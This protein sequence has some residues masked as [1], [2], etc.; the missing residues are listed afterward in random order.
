MGLF[1]RISDIVSANLNDLTEHYENPEKLLKQAI[2]EMEH[3]IADATQHTAR[4]MA[5]EKSLDREL[6]RNRQQAAQWHDRAQKAVNAGDDALACRALFRRREH[7]KLVAALQDQSNAARD[8]SRSL[9][10]Q[11]DDMRAKLSAAKRSLA[12]L[13]ARN[14]AADFGK[15]MDMQAARVSVDLDGCAFAKFERLKSR[16]E[17]AEAEAEA[18]SELRSSAQAA[19]GE[20]EFPDSPDVA[21]ELAELKRTVNK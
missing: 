17:Q 13:A 20:H 2:R 4:A 19:E 16:V 5:N 1:K 12:T 11:L 14:R 15:R 18:L 8:A 6:D 21:E 9:Q 10:C 7:A 3:T